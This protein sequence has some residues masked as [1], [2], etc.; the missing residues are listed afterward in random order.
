MGGNR[1]TLG[2]RLT[3]EKIEKSHEIQLWLTQ[4]SSN[5]MF[6]AMSMLSRLKFIS[7]DEYSS[8]LLIKLGA[9]SKLESVAVYAVRKFRNNAQCLWQ[10]NGNTQ[11][12]PAQT[13]G[14]EDLVSSIISNANRRHNNCF[15]DHPSLTVLKDK[16]VRHI[17]LL[18]DSVGSGKR[19]ADF[20]QL[21]TCSKTFMSWWSGGYISLHIL[22]YARTYQSE[23]AIFDRTPGSD[24]GNRKIRLSSKLKFDSDLVY[25]AYDIHTRWGNSSKSILS[26]C[27]SVKKVAKDRRKGFGDVMGN[28]VFY[29]SVPNN[30]PGMLVSSVKGWIPLFPNR[31]L[32][33][34]TVRLLEMPESL[35]ETTEAGFKQLQISSSLSDL[36]VLIKIGLRTRASLSRRLGCDELI[37]Q[38]LIDQAIKLGFVSKYLRMLKTG[39]G[40]LYKEQKNKFERKIDYSLYK[41]QSWCAD[42]GTVQPSDHDVSKARVQTDSIAFESMDGDDGES[43]LERTDAMAT[44]SPIMDVTQYPSWARERHIRNGPKGLKE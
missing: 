2:K 16:K 39:Q 30:I 42:Q 35:P 28:I 25:D 1:M 8:W 33:D 11:P 27:A 13:Q 4:F 38:K 18:D 14:S 15:L 6:T 43:S 19:V 9:Y 32:P 36:L 24:H 34:W 44:S 26:L 10:K 12:R 5:D 41:P 40:Y 31:S 37:T 3:L 7:R 17:I 23:K 29:H 21:M 20:L 22:S